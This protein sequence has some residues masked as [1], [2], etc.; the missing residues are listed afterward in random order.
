MI[1]LY[2]RYRTSDRR[3]QSFATYS[4]CSSWHGGTGA[5]SLGVAVHGAQC[6]TRPPLLLHMLDRGR[7]SSSD[8]AANSASADGGGVAGESGIAHRSALAEFAALSDDDSLPR[9]SIDISRRTLLESLFST[10]S[11][12][13][14]RGRRPRGRQHRSRRARMSTLS[15]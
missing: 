4:V 7:L 1:Y 8:N 13:A 10:E 6:P 2:T 14:H 5:V 3:G 11:G 15:K 12:I 9:S